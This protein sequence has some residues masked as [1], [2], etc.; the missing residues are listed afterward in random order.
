MA[1]RK[2]PR[3]PVS[4]SSAPRV[5][6]GKSLDWR[7]FSKRVPQYRDEIFCKRKNQELLRQLHAR[8]LSKGVI[9]A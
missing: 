1:K 7:Y 9:R 8:L 3:L 6:L 2:L 4:V 5:R